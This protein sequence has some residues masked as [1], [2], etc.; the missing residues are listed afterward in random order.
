MPVSRSAASVRRIKTIT[1]MG[2]YI[3]SAC[4]RMKCCLFEIF[5]G[6]RR[7]SLMLIKGLKK[8]RKICMKA[9]PLPVVEEGLATGKRIALNRQAD[10]EHG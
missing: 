7:L 4:P 1:T 5:H 2:L 6:A 3:L 9:L 8:I 10:A